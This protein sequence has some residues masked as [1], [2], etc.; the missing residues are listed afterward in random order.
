[1]TDEPLPTEPLQD[2]KLI[3]SVM[4]ASQLYEEAD[5]M[6]EG[7]LKQLARDQLKARATKAIAIALSKV[8]Y[9][10]SGDNEMLAG[11]AMGFVDDQNLD[12]KHADMQ[13]ARAAAAAAPPPA[14]PSPA[15]NDRSKAQNRFHRPAEKRFDPTASTAPE[16]QQPEPVQTNEVMERKEYY[17]AR[18]APAQ[19]LRV[20]DPMKFLHVQAGT[21]SAS[22]LS[23]GMDNAQFARNMQLAVQQ[24]TAMAKN[25]QSVSV[26]Y[27]RSDQVARQVQPIITATSS[28]S[29]ST[30]Y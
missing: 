29:S 24:I 13:K 18:G 11:V 15:Q 27:V 3:E 22:A 19:S 26:G 23:N 16:Q 17:T 6:A 21:V 1:M 5:K 28:S 30:I 20:H 25:P 2:E 12:K 7:S 8:R 9:D 4:Q 14:R 10:G